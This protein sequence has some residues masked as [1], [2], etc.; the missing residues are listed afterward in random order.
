MS[1][2][3]ESALSSLRIIADELA[4]GLRCQAC[5]GRFEYI[6]RSAEDNDLCDMCAK[7]KKVRDEIRKEGGILALLVDSDF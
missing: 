3:S 6:E 5:T 1:K 7:G 2:Q 4:A